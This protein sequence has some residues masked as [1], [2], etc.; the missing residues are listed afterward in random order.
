MGFASKKPKQEEDEN[1]YYPEVE[2]DANILLPDVK[3]SSHTQQEHPETTEEDVHQTT[4]YAGNRHP[5]TSVEDQTT[6]FG[7]VNT[8]SLPTQ[9]N[10][11]KSPSP[12][13]NSQ[14]F[15]EK[16]GTYKGLGQYF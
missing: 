1:N 10:N 9:A 13:L 11:S 12:T 3:P 16:N 5:K 2:A 14:G 4:A 7:L 6:L 8:N 15:Q